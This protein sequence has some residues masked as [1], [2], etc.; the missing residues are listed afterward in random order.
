MKTK[1]YSINLHWDKRYPL[2]G[3]IDLCPV[4]LALNLNG[5]QFKI[6]LKIYATATDFKKA[7]KGKGGSVEI[8]ELRKQLQDYVTKAEKILDKLPN[9]TRESF[10]RLFKSDA[11]LS[12][13]KTDVTILFNEYIHQLETEERIKTA[14]NLKWALTSLK[15]Y[16]PKL[17]FEDINEAFLRGYNLWMSKQ[18]NSSTTIQIYLRNLRTIF[19][20]AIKQGYISEKHYPFKTYTIGSSAKSKSVLYAPQLKSFW[21]YEPTTLRARRSK[22]Y[23]F[24]CYLCNGCNFKDVVYLKFKDLKSDTLSFIREKTKRTNKVADKRITVYLH[25]EIRRIIKTWGNSSGKPDD[26]IFPMLNGCTT[27]MEREKR[28]K[29]HQRLTNRFLNAMGKKL[30]FEERLTLNLARH[31][32]ATTLKIGGTPTSFISDAMG[33]ASST[34]TE[35]YLKSIPT[36]MARIMSNSLLSFNQPA[37]DTENK[38]D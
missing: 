5:L 27:A 17:Y 25:D 13:S 31:S 10:Q 21:E 22:D 28:R 1:N 23:F 15:K 34:T 29:T 36:D 20:V 8:R 26:Y 30:G 38:N 11:D 16:R 2:A 9:P 33:H 7:L 19:N 14:L 3:T 18:G 35:H 4:Q 37:S 32:F 12:S 6:S 24:M